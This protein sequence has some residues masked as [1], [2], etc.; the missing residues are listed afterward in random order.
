MVNVFIKIKEFISHSKI[1]FNVTKKP[2]A[3]EFKKTA[4]ISALGIL[5]IGLVGYLI[6]FILSL[7]F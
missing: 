1:V 6:T 4:L 7:L 2:T 5:F 3:D